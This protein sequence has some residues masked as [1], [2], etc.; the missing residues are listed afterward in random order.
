MLKDN[1][2]M[3]KDYFGEAPLP[4]FKNKKTG[5]MEKHQ[6]NVSPFYQ[7]L[8]EKGEVVSAISPL[9]VS[10]KGT[11][12]QEQLTDADSTNNTLTFAKNLEFIEIFNYHSSNEGK[13]EINGFEVNVPADSSVCVNLGG[14]LGKTVKVSGSTSYIVARYE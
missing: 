7:L 9:S 3:L 14:T 6:G 12:L 1:Q 10:T 2:R 11:V 5:K 13:F 4:Q 8:T